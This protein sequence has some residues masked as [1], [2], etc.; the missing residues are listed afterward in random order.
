MPPRDQLERTHRI[1][2]LRREA[3]EGMIRAQRAARA[4]LADT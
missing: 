1:V 3:H 4:D 2:E